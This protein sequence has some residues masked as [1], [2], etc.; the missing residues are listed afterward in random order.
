MVVDDI[1]TK[2]KLMRLLSID[3]QVSLVLEQDFSLIQDRLPSRENFL[4][5]TTLNDVSG[6]LKSLIEKDSGKSIPA[7]ARSSA[8]QCPGM[9]QCPGTQISVTLNRPEKRRS[10]NYSRNNTMAQQIY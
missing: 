3:S 6:I 1:T 8:L 4:A 10:K 7:L 2:S 5:M 9:S